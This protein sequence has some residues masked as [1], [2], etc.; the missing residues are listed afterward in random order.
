MT[1]LEKAITIASRA[2]NGQKDK[3]G[4][5]Y[6]LHPLR[7]MLQMKTQD[8]RIIAV[9]HDVIED[10]DYTIQD[11][12]HE[13]FE[14]EILNSLKLLTKNDKKV[15]YEDYIKKIKTN[16]IA[17]K[18]K[19]ADLED[20]MNL[21]RMKSLKET[22]LLR[23]KKYSWAWHFLNES[24]VTCPYCKGH[25]TVDERTMIYDKLMNK[26]KNKWLSA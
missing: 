14:E 22:D 1:L 16:P 9:L 19:I 7:L 3:A 17:T 12:R 5:E 11:L 10:S 26:G 20:N 23:F 15:T 13:G 18:I 6:I 8:E 21:T 25:G 4:C 24:G 2:H